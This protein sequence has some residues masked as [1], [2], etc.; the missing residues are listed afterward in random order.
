MIVEPVSR[1]AFSAPAWMLCQKT[2]G[3][4][5]RDDGDR[6]PA[7]LCRWPHALGVSAAS[8]HVSAGLQAY[9]ERV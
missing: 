2:C 9:V 7:T 3:R 4:A 5:L 6:Q 1:A 8:M